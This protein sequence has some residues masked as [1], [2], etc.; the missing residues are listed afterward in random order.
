[1][2][3]C[4]CSARNGLTPF[5]RGAQGQECNGNLSTVVLWLWALAAHAF[6]LHL[7]FHHINKPNIAPAGKQMIAEMNMLY[8]FWHRKR[9]PNSEVWD[10]RADDSARVAG[11]VHYQAR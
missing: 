10:D 4:I 7:A 2:R 9:L 1:M 8:V 11:T 3:I 5:R 6:G